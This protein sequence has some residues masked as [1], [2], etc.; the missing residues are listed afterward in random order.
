MDA[1]V[2]ALLKLILLDAFYFHSVSEHLIFVYILLVISQKDLYLT[3]PKIK[4]KFD[5]QSLSRYQSSV[6]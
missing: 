6:R 5:F 4:C 3:E 1:N 2:S